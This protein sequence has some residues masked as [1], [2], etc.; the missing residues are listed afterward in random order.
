MAFLAERL[1]STGLGSLV[2][3]SAAA[4]TPPPPDGSASSPSERARAAGHQA[5]FYAMRLPYGVQADERDAQLAL[6]FIRADES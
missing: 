6:G 5:V 1:T 3:A 4:S 2:L